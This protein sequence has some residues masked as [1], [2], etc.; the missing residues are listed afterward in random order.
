MWGAYHKLRTSS[1]FSRMGGGDFFGEKHERKGASCIYQY[2]SHEVFKELIKTLH[3]L[4][5]T[6]DLVI[7]KEITVCYVA[8]YVCRKVHDCLKQSKHF[9]KRSNDVVLVGYVWL[10]HWWR[11]P[12]W[13]LVEDDGGLWWVTDEV[14][15]LFY[16]LEIGMKKK[17]SR[18]ID[19]PSVVSRRA[20]IIDDLL[21]NED[22]LFQRCFVQLIYQVN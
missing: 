3:P 10:G 8:G 5:A 9:W 7:K 12:N 19:G 16:I 14:Y 21:R 22:L 20:D 4:N 13:C 15:Q 17:L 11:K 18:G 1:S 6:A 2:V